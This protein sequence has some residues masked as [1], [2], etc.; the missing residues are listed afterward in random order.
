MEVVFDARPGEDIIY[1]D[2]DPSWITGQTYGICGPLCAR[3]ASLV[4]LGLR[5]EAIVDKLPQVG[6][7]RHP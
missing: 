2:A 6:R 5:D 7:A 1:T 4:V 3:V